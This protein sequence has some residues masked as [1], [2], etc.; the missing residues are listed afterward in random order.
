MTL[1][2]TDSAGGSSGAHSISLNYANTYSI[3]AGT[4]LTAPEGGAKR[5]VTFTIS[6]SDPTV[7]GAVQWRVDGTG[8]TT[9]SD[10]GFL[11][12]GNG[13]LQQITLGLDYSVFFSVGET[14]KT[15]TFEVAGRRP[16][17]A[18]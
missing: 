8:G 18:G 9:A 6:R 4:G 1:T 2:F 17:R 7:T 16:C 13:F 12:Q 15:I 5:E 3:A 10:F 14:T 11:I